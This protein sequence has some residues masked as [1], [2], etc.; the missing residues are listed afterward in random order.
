MIFEDDAKYHLFSVYDTRYEKYLTPM[1]FPD[2]KTACIEIERAIRTDYER[3]NVSEAYLKDIEIRLVGVMDS[4]TG[5]LFNNHM[6][7]AFVIHPLDYLK[8]VEN[9]VSD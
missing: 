8:G 9:E 2:I 6:E 4:K 3:G 1:T 7:E 5:K